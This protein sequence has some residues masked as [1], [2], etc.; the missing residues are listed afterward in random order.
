M[1][2]EPYPPGDFGIWIIIYMELFTF[3]TFFIGYAFTRRANVDMFNESQLL[4][5]QTSGFINTL[6]LITSSIF[7]VKALNYIKCNHK[8]FKKLASRQLLYAMILGLVFLVI[9]LMEFSEKSSQ[10]ISIETNSFFMFYFILTAFHF[11]HVL[12]GLVILFN[13]YVNTKK[14]LYSVENYRGFETGA[15]YWHLVDLLWIVLFP[16][17]YIIR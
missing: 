16:L 15:A 5:S 2:K 14:S 13:L 8:D 6:I 17:I 11:F 3:T 10:G 4:L 7:I 12:L 1:K 9:K